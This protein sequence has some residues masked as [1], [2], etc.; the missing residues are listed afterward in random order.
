M[1]YGKML[2]EG[3]IRELKKLSHEFAKVSA[4][5]PVGYETVK[6]LQDQCH[7]DP[8]LLG[9]KLEERGLKTLLLTGAACSMSSGALYAYH[10]AALSSMLRERSG[11]L[12]EKCWPLTAEGFIRRIAIDW[13]EEKT[14]L[15]DLIADTFNN[16]THPGRTDVP[17]PEEHKSWN[18]AYLA[19][20]RRKVQAYNPV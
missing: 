10:D 18:P 4:V 7:Q 14:P 6:F 19:F 8:L 13:A 2:P 1:E 9:R 20:L 15:F 11:V 5:K 17:V 16:K 12:A 3:R